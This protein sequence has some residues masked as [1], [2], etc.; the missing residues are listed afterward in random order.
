MS[1]R[2]TFALLSLVLSASTALADDPNSGHR[3]LTG[4]E[5][6]GDWTTDAPGVRRKVT[7]EDLAQ[8]FAT[9]S[10]ENY[11][12]MVLGPRRPRASR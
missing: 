3:T 11:A 1:H 7:I 5:A 9:P 12:H 10:V 2:L 8:P 4:K 6:L